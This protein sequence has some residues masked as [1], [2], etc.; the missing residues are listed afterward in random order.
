MG[1]E[2][3]ERERRVL[4]KKKIVL[5]AVL[6]VILVF[7]YI[8]FTGTTGKTGE[9]K[10]SPASKPVAVKTAVV[11]QGTVNPSLALSGSV[12][13]NREAVITAKS[14]GI[15]TM[16]GGRTG[17]RVRAGQVV[18]VLE[19][20]QQHL[21][22]EKSREQEA[23]A[24]AALDKARTDYTRISQLFQQGAVSRADYENAE[25]SFKNAQ[26]AY[27]VAVSDRQLAGQLLKDTT[28]TSPFAGCVV[29][30]FA[31]E[32]EMIFPGTKLITV[33]DDSVLKIKANVTASQL[34]LVAVGQKGVFSA[35]AD[36]GKEF[37]CTV[38]SVSSRANQSN[39]TYAVELSLSGDAGQFLKPGM[40]GQV[41]LETGAVP[42]VIFPREAVVTRDESGE[43]EVFVVSADRAYRIKVMTGQ[44]DD[45][46]T[47]ALSGLKPSDRV[48][49]FGQS[50]LKDG[51]L[52]AEG[53]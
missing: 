6:L 20:N 36:P 43:A 12:S 32:G 28:V 10:E 8:K 1:L 22:V 51:S 19:S 2:K 45:R 14:Q 52:V 29:E 15:L 37:P 13:G 18:A 16:L 50:L 42:G 49:T 9:K 31:E 46:N 48:V 35:G 38:K 5:A 30:S 3:M 33:V 21:T 39:L 17:Q 23:S 25:I 26:A 53:E 24:G 40:F 4:N 41:R 44:S 34:K 7:A 47:M 27:N 11:V